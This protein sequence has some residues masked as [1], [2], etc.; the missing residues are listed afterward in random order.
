MH[1]RD[2]NELRATPKLK[3]APSLAQ[4]RVGDDSLSLRTQTPPFLSEKGWGTRRPARVVWSA[5]AVG[6]A[7]LLCGTDT[8]EGQP[9]VMS[10][11]P[12]DAVVR[13]T[14]DNADG[15]IDPQLQGLP[16]LIE[17]RIGGFT[18]T[19]PHDDRYDGVWDNA[20]AYARLDL[21]FDGLVNPPGPLGLGSSNPS[22][23]PFL[24]GPNPVYGFVELDIDADETT[25]GEL[26]APE[27]RYLGN[28][29]RFGGV[30]SG[31]RFADR[32][33]LNGFAFD[34]IVATAPFVDRSGEEF[35][36]A[37]LGEEISSIDVEYESPGGDPAV[38]EAGE[39]WIVEGEI[40]HR[41]HGFEDF[42]LMCFDAE[43][44]Y[45]A[46][47]K[48][49]FEHDLATD[50]TTASLVYP[51]TNAAWAALD[52]PSTPVESNDGC[53]DGQN[54]IEEALVD[55]QF[56]A[57]IADAGTRAL[58]EFQI[59]AGWEFKNPTNHLDPAAWR[60]TALFGTAYGV[61]QPDAAIFIWTDVYPNPRTG[62]F[63]GDAALDAT[64]TA[65]LNAFIT[66]NDGDPTYDDDGDG[67]N[68]SIDWA[69]YADNFC[70]FDTDYDGYV[71]ANDAIV[72]GDMDLN[73]LLDV[74][75]IDD[76][77]LSLLDS[78][79]YK[80][81]H[82]GVDPLLRGDI[83]ADGRLDGEDMQGFVTLLLN[84]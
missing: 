71:M 27:F 12:F 49:L 58:P 44:K 57:T 55:L 54:S 28:V 52:S 50:T 26:D 73:Q 39:T 7:V 72:L 25:G 61:A 24:H 34:E 41:A 36:L 10:D 6:V 78:D 84:P 13:R 64:D 18:P 60:V 21:V 38:F 11:A 4:Q 48:L 67:A 80:A 35:H 31:A 43:G 20:G 81:A 22:Y 17:M 23:D 3:G 77:I 33:A 62:D 9:V 59:I 29:A 14:D 40:V 69:G 42:A 47:V 70:V 16:E 68:G 66:T 37:F 46:E 75:D 51:L 1:A 5:L 2:A 74:D 82:G 79:G 65:A 19:M 63:N 32:V 45:E 8:A 83:S 53:A 56:S 30:P 76:F 15:A